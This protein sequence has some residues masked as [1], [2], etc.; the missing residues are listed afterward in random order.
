MDALAMP[1]ANARVAHL[2]SMHRAA[3]TVIGDGATGESSS[4]GYDEVVI[5]KNTETVD[6]FSSCVI[7]VK[8]ERAYTGEHINI[9]TQALWIQRMA[10]CSRA[11]WF[12][13]HTLS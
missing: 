13:M 11:S 7:P 4:N 1:W 2:L 3:A 10:L 9:M 8:A 12:K 6:A 5:T